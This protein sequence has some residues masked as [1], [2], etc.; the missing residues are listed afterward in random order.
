MGG[1][2]ERSF[3]AALDRG[4]CLIPFHPLNVSPSRPGMDGVEFVLH[5]AR[6]G[7]RGGL[8]LVSGED[9]RILQTVKKLAQVRH[10]H[11]QRRTTPFTT[12][13]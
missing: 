4:F 6:I 9:A 12:R 3:F 1:G 7:S 8:V 13:G 11:P 5:L 2:N 10:I